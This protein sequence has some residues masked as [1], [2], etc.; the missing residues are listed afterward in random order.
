M[1]LIS[2]FLKFTLWTTTPPP[3]TIDPGSTVFIKLPIKD[4]SDSAI[5]LVI[6]LELLWVFII[7]IIDF[8]E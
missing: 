7:L 3:K 4:P 2:I 6:F 5:L 8:P 1:C